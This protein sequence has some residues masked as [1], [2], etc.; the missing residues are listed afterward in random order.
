MQ[1][2]TSNVCYIT[3]HYKAIKLLQMYWNFLPT[4]ERVHIKHGV[5]KRDD[6][7]EG[8]LRQCVTSHMA[9]SSMVVVVL[10]VLVVVVAVV[11]VV[12]VVVVVLVVPTRESK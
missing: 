11:V 10:V 7:R 1:T 4:T 5:T 8:H 12:V 3:P 9:W 6:Q 2:F